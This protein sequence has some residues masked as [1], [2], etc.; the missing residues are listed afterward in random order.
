MRFVGV[1]PAR[2]AS[3]RLPGKPLLEIAGRT[4]IEWVYRQTLRAKV[5]ERVVVATDDQRIA[6]VVEGFGGEALMTR[7]DHLSG[8]DRVAEA[9]G[10]I[11]ADAFINVQGD[12]PL[13]APQTIERVAWA[14]RDENSLGQAS[15]ISTACVEIEEEREFASPDVVKVVRDR[16][17]RA[18]YFSRAPVPYRR[19]EKVPVFKHLGIYGYRRQMLLE[20]A[21]YPP[22]ALEKSE[23]L[24]QL[25][26]LENGIPIRVVEVEHDSLGVDTPDDL[27]RVRPLLENAP[28][29]T[30]L[31]LKAQRGKGPR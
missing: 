2:L 11:E 26:W 5:L 20:M 8:T 21:S 27:E 29:D 13:I 7:S 18:L 4:L 3:T 9:A 10:K 14:L 25:R 19:G 31:E 23:C 24:E 6:E 16:A 28:Q 22:T 30:V 12:E 17:G 1:I 15:P